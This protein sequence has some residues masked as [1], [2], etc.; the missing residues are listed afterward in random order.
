MAEY[1][2][3]TTQ[4]CPDNR[5][6][7]SSITYTFWRCTHNLSLQS[8]LKEGKNQNQPHNSYILN[9]GFVPLNKCYLQLWHM[10]KIYQKIN[11]LLFNVRSIL[12]LK[13]VITIHWRFFFKHAEK[14]AKSNA[15]HEKIT[16][17]N[18]S[19]SVTDFQVKRKEQP[20]VITGVHVQFW[21]TNT[22]AGKCFWQNHE[23]YLVG[24]I[25][26]GAI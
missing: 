17:S 18:P 21:R 10:R 12:F 16:N 8:I 4:T 9:T 2:F 1:S 14:T 6:Q 11:V 23:L 13:E 7:F 25:N 20:D 24:I 5:F 3:K 15:I 26:T 19:N 22:S